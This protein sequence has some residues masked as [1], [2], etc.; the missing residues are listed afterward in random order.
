MTY[1][2]E[3]K[4]SAL[5]ELAALPTQIANR[6]R[7]AIAALATTPRPVGSRK[8]TGSDRRYRI[9]ISNWRVVYEIFDDRLVV[10]VIAV[11]HRSEV[12]R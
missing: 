11:A 12:Y 1:T 2:I 4:A 7:A 6:A 9:R 8:L 5:K 10:S 3:I